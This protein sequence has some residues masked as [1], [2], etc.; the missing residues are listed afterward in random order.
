MNVVQYFFQFFLFNQRN[1]IFQSAKKCEMTSF[2]MTS[3]HVDPNEAAKCVDITPLTLLVSLS[4]F[5]TRIQLFFKYYLVCS[6]INEGFDIGYFF[7]TS[8][9]EFLFCITLR[10]GV[11]DFSCCI[12]S[13][14]ASSQL[15]GFS[16]DWQDSGL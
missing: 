11:S 15:N 8:T 9:L 6:D 7:F 13:I 3:L 1:Y 14:F 5:T 16:S 10:L 12:L 2:Y 4:I